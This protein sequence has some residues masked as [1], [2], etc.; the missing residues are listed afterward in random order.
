MITP[1]NVSNV[2]CFNRLNFIRT[3]DGNY[4]SGLTEQLKSSFDASPDY[5]EVYK[6]YNF[7]KL[8]KTR[9]FEGNEADKKLGFKYLQSYPY[10]MPQFRIGDYIHWKYDHINMSTWL[11]TS[12]DTQH[13]YD[14]KGRMLLCNNYL[15]WINNEGKLTENQNV[16]VKDGLVQAVITHCSTYVL[17]KEYITEG[18]D[19]ESAEPEDTEFA[20][21]ESSDSKKES[22]IAKIESTGKY[23]SVGSLSESIIEDGKN[24]LKTLIGDSFGK[25]RLALA[26]DLSAALEERTE[27]RIQVDG[28]T[29]NDAVIIL[30]KGKD[31]WKAI[32]NV[33]GNGYVIGKFDHF[34]PVLV[35]VDKEGE[36]EAAAIATVPVTTAPA[37]TSDSAN[38][39]S[40]V[41]TMICAIIVVVLRKAGACHR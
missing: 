18:E 35:F 20:E 22:T 8:Y 41:L 21:P 7:S 3:F 9:I 33:V 30:N 16:T 13:L 29:T 17:T 6:N 36:T 26:V 2:N 19:A 38:I 23:I 15:K 34:S 5:V 39:V 4:T 32:P 27:V 31:G 1:S 28:V 10:D 12:L 11:L 24:V 40:L 14:I 37:A 25:Y